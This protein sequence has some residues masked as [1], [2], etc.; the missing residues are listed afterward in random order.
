MQRIASALKDNSTVAYIS[1][2][3]YV[4]QD[5]EA[6]LLPFQG[7]EPMIHLL[8]PEMINLLTKLMRTFIKK[9]RVDEP[10]AAGLHTLNV[11]L[12]KNQRPVNAIDIGT[13]AKVLFAD[14]NFLPSEQQSDFRKDCVNFYV[15]P[16]TYLQQQLPFDN[17]MIKHAQYLHPIKRNDPESRS[18]IS[19]LALKIADSLKNRLSTVFNFRE[20][21]ATVEGICDLIRTQW[22]AYQAEDIPEHTYIAPENPTS[23]GRV[24]Q[25]YWDYALE[26]CNME[27]PTSRHS[28]YV[29]IDDYW[30][31]VGNFVDDRGC[32]KY[33]QLYALVK[34][35]LSQPWEC[36]T[37]AWVF[38]QQ[39]TSRVSWLYYRKQYDLRI[40]NC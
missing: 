32:M 4:S 13:K 3:A 39:V 18:A 1:F 7:E 24:Q 38:D 20:S 21:D 11:S 22:M 8:Y 28:T 15:T 27:P 25:S 6:F 34:C 10:T 2:C 19:N 30:S 12:E 29:R 23:S 37:R 40:E 36:C 26:I 31:K 5:F 35:V 33:L 9:K 14:V 16:V 17:L